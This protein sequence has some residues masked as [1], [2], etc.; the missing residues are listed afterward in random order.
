VSRKGKGEEEEKKEKGRRRERAGWDRRVVTNEPGEYRDESADGEGRGAEMKVSNARGW[1]S[2]L[3]KAA[4]GAPR[5][6][7]LEI[8]A[9]GGSAAQAQGRHGK[10]AA[11]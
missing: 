2:W 10:K 7:R 4:K 3:M 5:F 9:A 1:R 8:G 11:L 6:V